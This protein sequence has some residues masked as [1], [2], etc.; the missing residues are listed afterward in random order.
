ME[1]VQR[2]CFPKSGSY[3]V[4]AIVIE[5]NVSGFNEVYD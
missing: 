1:R 3:F 2:I 4:L 5:I